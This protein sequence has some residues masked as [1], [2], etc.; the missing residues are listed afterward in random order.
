[1][2]EALAGPVILAGHPDYESARRVWNGMHDKHPALIALCRNS[3][4]VS[5]AVNFARERSLLVAVRGGGH[6]WPGKSTCD[7]GIVIDLSPINAV[8][9]DP[10]SR[11]AFAGGGALLSS[12]DAAALEHGLITTT[13]IV[14]HTGVGGFTLG[15]GFGR[16]NRSYGLAVDNVLGAEMVTADGQIRTVSAD[17]EPA[18]FW[19]IRGGGGNFG[20]VT[21]FI[22]RLHPFERMLLAGA[23]AWPIAQARDVLNFYA[24]WYRGLSDEMYVA[25]RM[26]TLPDGTSVVSMDI[27]Y[28][29]APL[30]GEKELEPLRRIG[31]PLQDTLKVQDYTVT[32]TQMD[33]YMAHGIRSYAK[34]GMVKEVTS[35]LVDAWIESFLPDPRI[36]LSPHTAGGAVSRVDELATAFPQRNAELMIGLIG[37]WENP[38]ED[39][40]VIAKMRNWYSAM[41]PFT[42]GYYD[43]I[44]FGRTAAAG[45]YGPAY[46]R[47]SLIKG[48]YDPMN[49]FRLN[50]NIEPAA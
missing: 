37:R 32:Q 15:G 6:S 44:D 46:E 3:R 34:S 8:T 10:V 40:E 4:D 22:L 23:I 31:K 24:D 28:N 12:L 36:R 29:G 49:L 7:G 19:A 45:N 27:L 20:V 47:L 48:Q 41:E 9:V 16:L 14:S 17:N 11:E 25:P 18:L 43:N 13:G 42:G 1:L 21:R 26:L 2:G 35:A 33:R 50:S 39:D 38:D 5:H 30:A